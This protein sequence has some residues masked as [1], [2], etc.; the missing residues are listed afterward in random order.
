MTHSS[1]SPSERRARGIGDNFLRLSVGI[2]HVR[3]LEV[4]VLGALEAR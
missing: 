4:D 3:D 2:E 1:F